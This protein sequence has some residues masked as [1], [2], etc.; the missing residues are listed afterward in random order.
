MTKEEIILKAEPRV[1]QGSPAAGRLRRAGSL[2]AAM[3]RI[4]GDTTLLKL[5]THAFQLAMRNHVS[6][7]MLVS[8]ELDGA[9]IPAL[10][11]EI[12]RD[13]MTSVP[14]HVDFGE[15]SLA[16]KIRISIS[17]RLVGEP[18]GVKVGNG[19]LAQIMREIEVEC[20]PTEIVETLDIDVSGIKLGQSL[21]VRD[22]KLSAGLNVL[23]G[24]DQVV[25]T[26]AAPEQE[27]TTAGEA[28]ATPV[29][30]TK[31]KKD[32]AAASAAKK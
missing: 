12:Q 4:G 19:V 11:R 25:A 2:P 18:E 22:L 31:G 17:L 32:E 30:I 13:V 6:K 23:T 9:K 14:V 24:K 20:L 28:A 21:F 27:G 16:N 10:I 8:I 29:V 1:E 7:H 26:V 3:N 5:N 15:I